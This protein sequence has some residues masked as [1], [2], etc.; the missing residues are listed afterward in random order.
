[1]KKVLIRMNQHLYIYI[2]V[3]CLAASAAVSMAEC[4][5]CSCAETENDDCN[6]SI[7]DVSKS[8]LPDLVAE[9]DCLECA[10][11]TVAE[12]KTE[13]YEPYDVDNY[14]PPVLECLVKKEVRILSVLTH[15][16]LELH[17]SPE[18]VEVES[19]ETENYDTEKKHVL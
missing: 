7:A 9:T 18:M 13:S 16:F 5:D 2:P 17:V 19:H 14:H 1:M 15:E 6:N 12:V 10:P 11:E 8:L 4:V 3:C